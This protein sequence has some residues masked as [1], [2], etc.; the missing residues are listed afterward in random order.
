MLA[1]DTLV[2]HCPAAVADFVIASASLLFAVAM[3]FELSPYFFVAAVMQAT[4]L[5]A[6]AAFSYSSEAS[7]AL[8]L[9]QPVD[10]A[11]SAPRK[12]APPAFVI[13]FM[14]SPSKLAS[15]SNAEGIRVCDLKPET[16]TDDKVTA[17]DAR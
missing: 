5:Q 1:I 16:R 11:I 3:S 17:S 13:V 12:S 2:T 6:Q 4:S 14:G 7:S 9:P 8:L 10:K 15:F